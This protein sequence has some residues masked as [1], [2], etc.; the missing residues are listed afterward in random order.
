MG[1]IKVS[2]AKRNFSKI[3]ARAKRGEIIILQNG[4]DFMQLV[5]CV[6]PEPIP[7][8]PVGY[9]RATDEEAAQI[10]QAPADTGP[11]R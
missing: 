7:L 6:V 4:T 8:R 2:E 5:P 10:G 1:T 3:F 9:F 11:L